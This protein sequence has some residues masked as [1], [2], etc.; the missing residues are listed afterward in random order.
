MVTASDLQSR[1][2]AQVTADLECYIVPGTD[3]RIGCL[4]PLEYPSG[5]G[6]IVW[7]DQRLD[8]S[9]EVT[10]YSSAQVQNPPKSP[11]EARYLNELAAAICADV[12]VAYR[13]GRV[14]VTTPLDAIDDAIWRVGRASAQ[15]AGS[16]AYRGVALREPRPEREFVGLVADTVRAKQ[17]DVVRA[18]KL[19][20]ASGHIYKAT[21][22]L[23]SQETILEPIGA[24]GNWNQIAS[25]YAKFGDLS[26]ANGYHLFSVIDDR[27]QLPDEE[28]LRIL[29]QVSGVVSWSRKDDWIG[30][31]IRQQ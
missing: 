23:P 3:N 1:L 21:I 26:R 15:I 7:V 16:R 9:I 13:N 20:G 24:E 2:I 30:E 29:I 8:E 27:E 31:V 11:Q 17:V 10:D 5:D 19:A 12:D 25:L 28:I 18:E 22:Y 6:V 14:T 4:L